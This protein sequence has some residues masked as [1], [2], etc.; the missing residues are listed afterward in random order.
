MQHPMAL[1]SAKNITHGFSR[2]NKEHIMSHSLVKI[3]VHLV[4][5]TK[6]RT[7]LIPE[8]HRKEI[9]DT[10]NEI[11]TQKGCRVRATVTVKDHFHSLFLLS[12]DINIADIVR[13]VKGTISRRINREKTTGSRFSWQTGYGAFSVSESQLPVMQKYIQNQEEHHRKMSYQEEYEKFMRIYY[14]DLLPHG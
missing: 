11:L 2:G 12:A 8:R 1:S 5:G 10:I 6:N 4:S 13:A 3:W 9:S 7:I 14:P